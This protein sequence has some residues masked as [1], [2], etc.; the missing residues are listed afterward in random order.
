MRK[1][2]LKNKKEKDKRTKQFLVGAILIAIMF[3]SV[4]GYS[5]SGK[6]QKN[7]NKVVYNGFE[8]TKQDPYWISE[9]ESLKFVFTYNPEETSRI[10]S[11]LK[12]LNNYYGKP[13][14]IYSDADESEL[15]IYRNLDPRN[16]PIVQR[17]QPACL[18]EQKCEGDLP[19]KTCEDN[20]IIIKEDNMTTIVQDNNC[21]FI[22]AS[23]EDL[24]KI[25]DEFLFKLF[26]IVQ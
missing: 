6:D 21:V 14:Y 3:F 2:N 1:I 26:K 19:I 20:F 15:E 24:T 9:K 23:K 13:L 18:E 11:Y 25:T 22:Q 16:N 8:F 4:L 12:D 7:T 10:D 17:I 5:F